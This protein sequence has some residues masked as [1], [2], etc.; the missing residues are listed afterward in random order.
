MSDKDFSLTASTLGCPL[1]VLTA[2]SVLLGTRP[3]DMKKR[4]VSSLFFWAFPRSGLTTAQSLR[5]T[6]PDTCQGTA[7]VAILTPT[8]HTAFPSFSLYLFISLQSLKELRLETLRLKI[9]PSAAQ[10]EAKNGG[11][12]GGRREKK[13]R[14]NAEQEDERSRLTT[15]VVSL[16]GSCY[17]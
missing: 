8:Q 7:I 2:T 10:K 17:V 5:L 4:R 16:T 11:S 13:E 12:G 15:G 14:Q 3:S 6:D 1:L 9:H